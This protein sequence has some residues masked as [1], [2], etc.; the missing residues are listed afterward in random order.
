VA[1]VDVQSRTITLKIVY[2]GC[3]LGGKTTNLVTLHRLTDP[4]SASGLVSI[5]TKDDRTLFFDLLP[6]NLGQIGAMQVKVKLYTV[7]GQVHYELTRRQVL[8]GADGVVM[9]VD[10]SPDQ[11][12]S[13]QWAVEN[14]RL[15]LR[16]NGLDP[17]T[18]P[19]VMQWNKRDLPGARLVTE[20]DA[21]LNPQRRPHHEAIATTGHGV[22]ETFTAVLERAIVQTYQKYGRGDV[23]PAVISRTLAK[24]MEAARAAVP[25]ERPSVPAFDHRFDMDAY[26]DQQ[27][28]DQG[29]DRRIVDE[30]SLLSEAVNTNML[31]AE[32]LDEYTEARGQSDRRLKMMEALG[33]LAPMLTDPSAAALP[34]GAVELLV[35]GAGRARGS[36]LLFKPGAGVMDEREVVGGAADPLNGI[37]AEGLGSVAFR[38]LEPKRFATFADLRGEVLFDAVPATMGDVTGVHAAPLACDGIAFGGLLVYINVNEPPIDEAEAEFW[39]TAATLMGLSLHWRAM[40]RKLSQMQAAR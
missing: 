29:R 19:I 16:A 25:H 9:V 13:N 26:R 5:A 22:G 38:L 10:S 14:L 12:K 8:G 11:E 27:A 35:S 28:T 15:N 23:A 1:V 32:K 40:R 3:A 39:R 2:F 37:V 4:N 20:L 33:Q 34:P 31:L 36:M 18:I 7:P 21:Q 6:M 17:D 30:Q 24:A